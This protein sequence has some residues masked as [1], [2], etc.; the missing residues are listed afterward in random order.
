MKSLRRSIELFRKNLNP[1]PEGEAGLQVRDHRQM[2]GGM[3][4][5][6][7]QL[8]FDY[9][10]AEGLKPSDTLLDIGCGSF[11]AGRHFIQYLDPGNYLGI[12]KQE[13]LVREGQKKE[14]GDAVWSEKQPEIVI[15]DRF[16]FMK[17]SKQPRIAI[18]QS[19]FTHISQRDIHRCL[20]NLADFLHQP[21]S[22]YATFSEADVASWQVLPSHSSRRFEYTR[23]E[24]E[25]IGARS[26]WRT[27]Y[28][29]D[30]NHPRNQKMVIYHRD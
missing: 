22:L 5:Q 15:S 8:Q 29:G 30:W 20:R 14:V 25:A 17:F 24:M 19:V 12:D 27:E 11:R 13:P 21:C 28:V 1:Y 4:Q 16:D 3:W 2:V 6:I 23:A 18:A 10:L 7:G 9:L 26:G